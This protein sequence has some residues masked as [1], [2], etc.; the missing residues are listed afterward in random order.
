MA[1][2]DIV[3]VT[4]VWGSGTSA[5]SSVLYHLGV[6]MGRDFNHKPKQSP[7]GNWEEIGLRNLCHEIIKPLE[8]PAERP[9]LEIQ[10]KLAVWMNQQWCDAGSWLAGGKHPLLTFVLPE[11]IGAAEDLRLD[12]QII[13]MRRVLQSCKDSMIRRFNADPAY[14]DAAL[15]QGVLASE[16][17]YEA[18]LPILNVSLAQLIRNTPQVLDWIVQFLDLQ[19]AETSRA[20]AEAVISEKHLHHP[21]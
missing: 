16:D 9:N 10:D 5:M 20:E 21:L 7:T 12:L 3:L 14:V 2:C 17:H 1:N 6:F 4:G 19:P 18:N 11:L 15:T 8:L 13:H